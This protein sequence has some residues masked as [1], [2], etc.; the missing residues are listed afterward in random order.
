MKT[1]KIS[2]TGQS[3]VCVPNFVFIQIKGQKEENWIDAVTY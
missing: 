2:K 1:G 3:I